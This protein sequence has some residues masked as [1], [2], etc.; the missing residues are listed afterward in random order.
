MLGIKRQLVGF[1]LVESMVAV[2]IFSLLIVSAT[3]IFLSIIKSQRNTLSS[4]NA[5][6]S[7][8]YALEVMTKELRMAKVDQGQC[9]PDVF[10]KVYAVSESGDQIKFLNYHDVCVTYWLKQ[11]DSVPGQPVGR[12]MIQRGTDE[13]FMTPAN[14]DISQLNFFDDLATGQPLATIRFDLSYLNSETGRQSL[15]VQTS[16]SSR[17]YESSSF[18]D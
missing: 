16:V 4:K 15:Q 3:D 7:V 8:S 2:A 5:Q 1:T 12:L 6:E 17:S 11:D 9:G 10:Q 13:A 14:I 18:G